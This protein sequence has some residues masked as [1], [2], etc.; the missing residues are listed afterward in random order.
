LKGRQPGGSLRAVDW[1]RERLEPFEKNLYNATDNSR[2]ADPREVEAFRV[3]QEIAVIKDVA[4]TCPN[5]IQRFEDGNFPDYI[6]TEAGRSPS[7]VRTWWESRR[8]APA[9]PWA[10]CCLASSTATTSPT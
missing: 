3:Q 2:N 7:L 1:S 5:P 8:L 9:K 4:R 6:M 10:T